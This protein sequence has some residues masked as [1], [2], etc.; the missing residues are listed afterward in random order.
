MKNITLKNLLLDLIFITTICI[1]FIALGIVNIFYEF[2]PNGWIYAILAI[3]AWIIFVLPIVLR[4]LNVKKICTN[5]E[6]MNSII[7]KK[8]CDSLMHNGYY[9]DVKVNGT[10]SVFSTSTK[11]RMRKEFSIGDE[12]KICYDEKNNEVIIVQ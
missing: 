10:N 12:V 6:I 3:I 8:N 1:I 5:N 4:Y 11:Y 9:Y 2:I 7:I